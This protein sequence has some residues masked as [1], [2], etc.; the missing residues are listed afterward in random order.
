VVAKWLDGSME[1]VQL[2]DGGL[3]RRQ[4]QFLELD[5]AESLLEDLMRDVPWAQSDIKIYG[6]TYKFASHQCSL[7]CA[8]VYDTHTHTLTHAH[9][10]RRE[11]SVGWQR[12]R[13]R[14]R[15]T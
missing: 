13:W 8:L 11:C 10:D 7:Q 14:R 3:F 12:E 4:A 5:E 9:T 1:M 2:L 6:K 15:P